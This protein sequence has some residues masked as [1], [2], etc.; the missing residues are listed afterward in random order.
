[1]RRFILQLPGVSSYCN[2]SKLCSALELEHAYPKSLL[3]RKLNR[4]DFLKA[5]KDPHNLHKCCSKM[6]RLKAN[7]LLGKAYFHEFSGIIARSCLYMNET[8]SLKTESKLVKKWNNLSLIYPP[9]QDELERSKII[10]EEIG[11]V[12]YYIE[13]Y[14]KD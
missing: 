13:K 8:Y 4:S 1:M 11:I 7:H 6:N 3:K 12:N 2:C 10:E 5:N 9:L 14:R